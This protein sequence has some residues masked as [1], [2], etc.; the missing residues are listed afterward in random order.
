M[1]KIR[2]CLKCVDL[3]TM[4]L[5]AYLP[6]FSDVWIYVFIYFILLYSALFY[7]KHP[8]LFLYCW[9]NL[10]TIWNT[11]IFRTNKKCNLI[12][13]HEGKLLETITCFW[14]S[15][16]LGNGGV[17][18]QVLRQVL[19]LPFQWIIFI[20]VLL[21]GSPTNGKKKKCVCGGADFTNSR[22]KCAAGGKLS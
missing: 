2:I 10:V 3:N 14:S 1:Q 7:S 4:N 8:V 11:G 15:C 13:R 16:Q 5:L 18:R 6:V 21:N 19:K 12:C 9:E 17:H 22:P 20:S